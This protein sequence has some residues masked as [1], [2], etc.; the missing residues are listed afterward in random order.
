MER[1]G[2][3]RLPN[4]FVRRGSG[5][6]SASRKS[7]IPGMLR[8][9]RRSTRSQFS[10]VHRIVHRVAPFVS[11]SVKPTPVLLSPPF[12]RGRGYDFVA[13]R[14]REKKEEESRSRVAAAAVAITRGGGGEYAAAFA[15]CKCNLCLSPFFSHLPP[16]LLSLALLTFALTCPAEDTSFE[17]SGRI[18]PP[19]SHLF[20]ALGGETGRG[21]ECTSLASFIDE[22]GRR[23][24]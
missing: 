11:P 14:R 23:R 12:E 18:R 8:T 10:Y 9:T 7:P 19:P 13:K 4:I 16:N 24:S 21:E 3:E 1:R 2:G 15:A 22:S 6:D 5:E 17:L 20:F